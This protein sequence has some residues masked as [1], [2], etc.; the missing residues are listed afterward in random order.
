MT[1]ARRVDPVRWEGI[2]R[3]YPVEFAYLFG[4]RAGGRGRGMSDWDFGVH[5]RPASLRR[6]GQLALRLGADLE[7]RLAPAPVDMVVLNTAP[8]LL[9]HRVLRGRLIYCRNDVARARF[10]HRTLMAYLD[11]EPTG[12]IWTERVLRSRAA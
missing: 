2:F 1:A 3:R 9:R 7:R 11:F 5:F 8:L 4:S 6:A 12:R 10:A